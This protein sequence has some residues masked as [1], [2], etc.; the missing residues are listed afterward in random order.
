MAGIGCARELMGNRVECW[1][2]TDRVINVDDMALTAQ[3]LHTL[4][5]RNSSVKL[6]LVGIKMHDAARLLLI[7]DTD[8]ST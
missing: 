2:Q 1:L 5:W 7:I 8:V 3:R 6:C 4:C